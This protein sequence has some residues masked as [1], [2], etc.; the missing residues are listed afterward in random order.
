MLSDNVPVRKEKTIIDSFCALL[1]DKLQYSEG[2]RDLVI[3][4]HIFKVR[5]EDGR[6][7]KIF[8]TLVEYGDANGYSAMAKTVGIPAAIAT[9]LLLDGAIIRKGVIGPFTPDIYVPLL[10]N[11]EK[12]GIILNEKIVPVIL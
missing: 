5:W 10:A 12:E 7:E 2:E 1:E 8:S 11:L 6:E 9:K 3:L 4:H